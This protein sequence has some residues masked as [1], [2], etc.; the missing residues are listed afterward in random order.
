MALIRRMSRE[1]PLWG[2]PRIHS[3]LLML[4]FD[5]SESTVARY[6]L[7]THRPPSQGWK[8]FLRNHAARIASV[9]LFI[10]TFGVEFYEGQ[11]FASA[12]SNAED[13]ALRLRIPPCLRPVHSCCLSR[14]LSLYCGRCARAYL[15]R[16]SRHYGVVPN[17]SSWNETVRQPPFLLFDLVRRETIQQQVVV[18][19]EAPEL[20]RS[21]IVGFDKH[22]A[23]MGPPLLIRKHHIQL[24]SDTRMKRNTSI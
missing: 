15:L 5:I 11:P 22:S 24:W 3:E 20:R 7:R 21:K 23:L 19:G 8:T 6:M 13:P 1:N 10:N 14:V 17:L 12:R 16:R 2:A 18:F 4:G 9:D